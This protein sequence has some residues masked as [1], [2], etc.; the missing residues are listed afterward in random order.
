MNDILNKLKTEIPNNTSIIVATSGG[1]DSMALLSLL[2]QIKKELLSF[3]PAKPFRKDDCIDCIASAIAM[4]EV[5][6]PYKSEEKPKDKQRLSTAN[7][8][9]YTSSWR[10]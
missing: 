3:N 4:S 2:N 10:V 6:A 8:K 7:S 1:P 9:I 5:S